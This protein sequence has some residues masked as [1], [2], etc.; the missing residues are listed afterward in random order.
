VH[1]IEISDEVWERLRQLAIPFE[2]HTPDDVLRRELF[3]RPRV[4]SVDRK[5]PPTWEGLEPNQDPRKRGR[6]ERHEFVVRLRKEGVNARLAGG[7]RAYIEK[8]DTWLSI[9]FATE[10]RPNRWFLGVPERDLTEEARLFIILLCEDSGRVLGVVLSPE[11]LRGI[12]D[13]ISRSGG[14][15][16]FNLIRNGKRYEL[17]IPHARSIDVSDRVDAWH[18]FSK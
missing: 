6:R 15:L 4:R 14:Q 1:T 11:L 12:G 2:D 9:P 7:L 13:Q 3:G 8:N 5:A 18:L 16:K 10:Q 17:L